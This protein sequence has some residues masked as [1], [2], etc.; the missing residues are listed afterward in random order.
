M[1]HET[2]QSAPPSV[3][4]F[5]VRWEDS[6][7]AELFWLMEQNHYPDPVTPADFSVLIKAIYGNKADNYD[8]PGKVCMRHINTYFYYASI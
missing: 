3:P 1:S 5:P 2:N 7:D 8:I 4:D 6:G